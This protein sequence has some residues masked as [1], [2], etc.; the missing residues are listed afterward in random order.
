[1][2][3]APTAS[4]D[5]LIE[6]WKSKRTLKQEDIQKVKDKFNELNFKTA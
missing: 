4:V 1:M 2:A 5:E 3:E 6:E